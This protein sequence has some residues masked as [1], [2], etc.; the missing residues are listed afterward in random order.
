[1]DVSSVTSLEGQRSSAERLEG[2]SLARRIN[3][4]INHRD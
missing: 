4:R 1:M 2:A 3:H